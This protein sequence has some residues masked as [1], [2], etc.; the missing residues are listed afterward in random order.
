M[1]TWCRQE[2]EAGALQLRLLHIQNTPSPA[3]GPWGYGEVLPFSG[4]PGGLQSSSG[5]GESGDRS[6]HPKPVEGKWL[7]RKGH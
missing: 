7:H 5:E 2:W 3:P 1:T 4:P 6:S